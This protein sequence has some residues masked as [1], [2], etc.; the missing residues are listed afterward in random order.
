ML[1]LVVCGRVPS[2]ATKNFSFTAARCLFFFQVLFLNLW[3][4]MAR[5]RQQSFFYFYILSTWAVC[6]QHR[7][8]TQSR[9]IS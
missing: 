1:G 9:N 8:C 5:I 3:S 6:G 7:W 2:D 4:G